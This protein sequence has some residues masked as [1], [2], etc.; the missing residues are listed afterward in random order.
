M[1]APYFHVI[2]RSVR[3]TPI[4]ARRTDYRAFLGILQDGFARFP[5]QPLAYCLMSNHWHLVLEPAGTNALIDL[6]H[7]VT[8]THAI[9]WHRHHKTIGQGH[10]YQGRYHSVPLNSPESLMRTCRYVER[11]ALTAGLVRRAEDWPWSSLTSRLSDRT[12]LPLKSAP[13]FASDAWIAYVNYPTEPERL[14]L[15]LAAADWWDLEFTKS[16][17]PELRATSRSG[18]N[19][20]ETVEKRPDPLD[21][22]QPPGVRQGAKDVGNDGRRRDEN[23]PDAHVERAEH[24]VV[25]DRPGAL[26]P[27]EHRRHGPAVPIE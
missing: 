1:S 26:K 21:T 9:R 4:F 14:G 10:L 17:P 11:N 2:N 13:F 19:E 5:V 16:R 23:E 6:M 3:R 15:P 12:E 18:T 24:L 20:A 27:R 25:V 8:T 7:W 22:P